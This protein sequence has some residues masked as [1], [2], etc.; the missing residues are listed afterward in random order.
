M[1]PDVLEFYNRNKDYK[2]SHP[3]V[4]TKGVDD[5]TLAQSL[6]N[7]PDFAWIELDIEFD[8]ASWII[9]LHTHVL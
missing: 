4:P 1:T 9:N 2:Y 3:L 8:L 6:V 7:H 5:I